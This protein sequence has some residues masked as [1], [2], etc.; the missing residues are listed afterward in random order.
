MSAAGGENMQRHRIGGRAGAESD[1]DPGP[2]SAT[3]RDPAT[4]A[5]SKLAD[6]LRG[7]D[8]ADAAV[9]TAFREVP[10]HAF[11]PEIGPVQ[12]YE[13]RAV[14][15][16]S[17]DEGLPISAS[18]QPTMMA[19]MLGQ[20]GLVPGHRVLE[21]GTGTGYNAALIACLVE[22][23]ESVVTVD[24][25]P[26]LIEHARANLA[27]A[28]YGGVRVVCGDGADGV[29]DHAPY[30]R[31]IVT[32]GV[33][34]LAPQWRAQ[35]LPAGRIVLPLSIRGIQLSVG[36]ETLGDHLVSSSA[37]RCRFIRMAGAMTGPES[38]I[39]LGTQP[40]LHA[41][42]VDGP[43]PDAKELY[44]ALSGPATEELT[45]LWA[46]SIAELADLDLWLTLSEPGLTRLNMLGRHEAHASSAQQR[47]ANLMPL[48]G[49][50]HVGV[51]GFGVA[52]F[53]LGDTKKQPGPFEIA[54]CG[55]G[56]GGSSLARHLAEQAGVWEE[57]GRP[58]AEDLEVSAWLPET[59]LEAIGE[60][61]VII[62]RPHVRLAVRWP[63]S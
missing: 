16:K 29:P 42:A 36:L 37:C 48:G 44:E 22:S 2:D 20:L 7:S 19:V 39:A 10:R 55:Y 46:A 63:A 11:L 51:G 18:T 60:A 6:Y 62:D 5:R 15:T 32:A 40:G 3:D 34:D 30:D 12:A 14:V 33:W 26:E 61:S 45:G 28:G 23:Q 52:A 24:V 1:E 35:L 47:I 49:L 41:H 43:V 17:D 57:L 9:E 59:P 27:A 58:G 8:R 53:S 21:V 31:I 4:A 38:F 13:D 56:P 50:A 25:I 54:A